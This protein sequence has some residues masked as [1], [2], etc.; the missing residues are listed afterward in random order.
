MGTTGVVALKS[1]RNFIGIEIDREIGEICKQR[2][3]RYGTEL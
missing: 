1:D 2:L 3:R